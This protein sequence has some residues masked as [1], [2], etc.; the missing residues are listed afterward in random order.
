MENRRRGNAVPGSPVRE[1]RSA[2]RSGAIVLAAVALAV[3][4][5]GGCSTADPVVAARADAAL[6]GLKLVEA[7][8]ELGIRARMDPVCAERLG[9]G[10]IGDKQAAFTRETFA[11]LRQHLE[12][13]RA[14]GLGQA[15]KTSLPA[16]PT[17]D[18]LRTGGSGG[19]AP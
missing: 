9:V 6:G 10:V 4:S 18:A 15:A 19:G 16:G 17:R 7:D 2:L 8:A 5:L 12:A 3:L 13:L 11:F 14:R 1:H